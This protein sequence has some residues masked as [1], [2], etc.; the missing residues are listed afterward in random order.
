MGMGEIMTEPGRS[1]ISAGPGLM[2]VSVS[3]DL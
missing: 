2:Q 1:Q 3:R